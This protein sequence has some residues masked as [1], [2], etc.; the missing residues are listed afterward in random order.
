VERGDYDGAW[1]LVSAVVKATT[2]RRSFE[3]DL[4]ADR[5]SRQPDSRRECFRQYAVR[6][7]NFT[8]G[9]VLEACFASARGAESVQVRLDDDQEWRVARVAHFDDGEVDD[10]PERLRPIGAPPG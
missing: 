2:S 3:D 5:A 4:R 9:D 6:G 7:G 1:E 8:M 10:E